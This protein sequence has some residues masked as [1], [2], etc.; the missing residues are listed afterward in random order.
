MNLNEKEFYEDKELQK[1]IL[2]IEKINHELA[3]LSAS[4]NSNIWNIE[5]P[6]SEQRMREFFVEELVNDLNNQEEFRDKREDLIYNK[7][8][9]KMNDLKAN[10][11]PKDFLESIEKVKKINKIENLYTSPRVKKFD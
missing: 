2:D 4:I 1:I 10:I 5:N 6:D 3:Y 7:L 9:N 8:A 11:S